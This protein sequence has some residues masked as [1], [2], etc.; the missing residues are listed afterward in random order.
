MSTSRIYLAGPMTGLPEF[1]YPTFAL[2]AERL[3]EMGHTVESPHE[4]GQVEGWGWSDYMRRGLAQMLTCDMV[5]LLPGW[6]LSRGARIEATIAHTL[7]MDVR[8]L[9]LEVTPLH[10]YGIEALS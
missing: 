10:I 7:G 6:M 3:R 9:G 1:N 8:D 2:V 5:V 4:P